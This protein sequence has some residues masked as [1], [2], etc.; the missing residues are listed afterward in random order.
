MKRESAVAAGLS[1]LLIAIVALIGTAVEYRVY[2][3]IVQVPEC[4]TGGR[5]GLAWVPG[6]L[7][8]QSQRDFCADPFYHSCSRRQVDIDRGGIPVIT[9]DLLNTC[10]IAYPPD[11]IIVTDLG[12]GRSQY[13]T[14]VTALQELADRGYC[15]KIKL[16]N[17]PE[18][19]SQGLPST[20]LPAQAAAEWYRTAVATIPC[21]TFITPN[22]QSLGYLRG[23]LDALGEGWRRTDIIGIHI[24]QA[25]DPP[26][27]VYWPGDWIADARRILAQRGITSE[28]WVSEVGPSN[29][30]SY[31]DLERYYHELQVA[32]MVF[33]FTPHCFAYSGHACRRNLYQDTG[34]HGLTAS[35]RV[36]RNIVT[37]N[38]GWQTHHSNEQRLNTV[39][40][41]P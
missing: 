10:G 29:A 19:L 27:P 20:I 8:E 7:V 15:G 31:P 33:V 28:V 30:W 40:G 21:A 22:A 32:D 39:Q 23:F 3:P 35:G 12:Y 11:E 24:Y 18:L 41:Y 6:L 34:G 38:D 2:Y 1:G 25:N 4:D 17:E 37:G 36:F 9:H 26:T 16:Y 5:W 13:V 14:G